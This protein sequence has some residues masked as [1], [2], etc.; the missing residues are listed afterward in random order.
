MRRIKSNA[1]RRTEQH[2][3]KSVPV[4]LYCDPRPLAQGLIS[5]KPAWLLGRRVTLWDGPL[6]LP[7]RSGSRGR[8]VCG[9]CIRTPG[10]SPPDRQ[11]AGHG[12]WAGLTASPKKKEGFLERITWEASRCAMEK[13]RQGGLDYTCVTAPSGSQIL[14]YLVTVFNTAA[15][16][17]LLQPAYPEFLWVML[18]RHSFPLSTSV[19]PTPPPS[20]YHTLTHS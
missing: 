12:Q 4:S 9:V 18:L 10:S 7:S 20:P 13:K 16:R 15:K 2:W 6:A 14:K 17:S 8:C 19:H 11:P 5:L 1:G 3:E